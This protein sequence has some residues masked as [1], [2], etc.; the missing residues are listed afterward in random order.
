[1]SK[2]EL[3]PRPGQFFMFRY[4]PE[5]HYNRLQYIIGH[6]GNYV[7]VIEDEIETDN[8]MASASD[9]YAHGTIEM[10]AHAARWTYQEDYTP[11]G[12]LPEDRA[13]DYFTRCGLM[14]EAIHR[15][16]AQS[17]LEILAI[18]AIGLVEP[19]SR[20]RALQ[21]MAKDAFLRISQEESIP[22]G[23]A[24]DHD[25]RAWVQSELNA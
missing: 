3:K 21:S 8:P 1:M 10:N 17:S 13:L 15:Y 11:L 4:D 24:T 19:A 14:L 25:Y 2:R 20:R 9:A 7:I 22:I 23:D 16:W 18:E 12:D 5:R 6:A